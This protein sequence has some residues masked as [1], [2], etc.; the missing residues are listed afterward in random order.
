MHSA[1][2]RRRSLC[3]NCEQRVED[4]EAQ[5]DE[6]REL[7]EKLKGDKM[8]QSRQIEALKVIALCHQV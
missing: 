5:L 4:L 2:K 6:Q 7:V 1:R 3:G 8:E